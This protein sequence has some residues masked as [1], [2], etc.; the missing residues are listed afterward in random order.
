[1]TQRQRVAT[2]NKVKKEVKIFQRLLKELNIAYNCFT[3]IH[4]SAVNCAIDQ[5]FKETRVA[6]KNIPY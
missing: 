5:S 6:G 1:M 4:I 3:E 2:F